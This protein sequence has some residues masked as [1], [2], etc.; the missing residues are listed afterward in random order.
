MSQHKKEGSC[1]GYLHLSLL[2]FKFSPL[3]TL[4]L[5]FLSNCCHASVVYKYVNPSEVFHG[6]SDHSLNIFLPCHLCLNWNHT[7]SKL[8]LQ[9]LPTSTSLSYFLAAIA[10]FTPDSASVSAKITR[11]PLEA[12]VTIPTLPENS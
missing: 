9:F 1:G 5:T 2:R 7:Y 12:P 11:S 3:A 8:F 10:T 4:F 6:S